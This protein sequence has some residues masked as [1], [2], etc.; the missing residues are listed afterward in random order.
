[1]SMSLVSIRPSGATV[2]GWPLELDAEL[3]DAAPAATEDRLRALAGLMAHMNGVSHASADAHCHGRHVRANVT[4]QA[5]DLTEAVERA[6]ALVHSSALDA[7]LGAVILVAV[8]AEAAGPAERG[9]RA[10]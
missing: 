6:V 1:M 2:L 5:G 8:R 3:T 9:L 4:M 10:G 7:G